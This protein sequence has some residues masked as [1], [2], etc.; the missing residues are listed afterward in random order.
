MTHPQQ[1][2]T[3]NA[4]P[5]PLKGEER[6]VA[7]P[8]LQRQGCY[9]TGNGDGGQA[10]A[11]SKAPTTQSSYFTRDGDGGQLCSLRCYVLLFFT[12]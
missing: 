7:Y 11:P 6:V 9:Q 8:Q 2:L 12:W 3:Q 5:W 4:I 10:T 1:F